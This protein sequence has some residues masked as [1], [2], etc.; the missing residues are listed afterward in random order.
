M[1]ELILASA[2]P[3]RLQLLSQIA[4][5]PDHVQPADIDETP[6]RSELPRAYAARL[7]RE[8]ARAV[9]RDMAFTLAGDTVVAMGRRILPKAETDAE[10]RTCLE[11]LSGQAH[12]VLTSVCL[13]TPDGQV[14]ERLS[15]TRVK[16]K[17]LS[18]QEIDAYIDCEE[19][20]GKAG[21]YAIQGQF[22]AH[23]QML[24]GS[25]FGVMGLPLYETAQLLNGAGYR[26]VEDAE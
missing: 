26:R 11:A 16:V 25:Y 6:L 20:L 5:R 23:I 4:I 10:V 1:T 3:R 9:H 8:K 2:S 15:S 13:M 24:S 7:G 21:G 18:G 19:G 22:A 17:R 14:L 12:R